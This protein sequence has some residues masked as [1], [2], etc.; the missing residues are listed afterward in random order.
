MKPVTHKAEETRY[1][2]VHLTSLHGAFDPRIFFREAVAAEQA[3]YV[4]VVIAPG[5]ETKKFCGIEI[6]AFPEF[7]SRFLRFLFAPWIMLVLALRQRADIYQFHDPELMPMGVMLRFLGK[8]VVY[9]VHEDLPRDVYNKKWLPGFLHPFLSWVLELGEKLVVKV[10]SGVVAS[11]PIIACRFPEAKTV[12]VRNFPSPESYGDAPRALSEGRHA[13]A[14]YV[15][16]LSA[17]RGLNIMLEAGEKIASQRP[18]SLLLAGQFRPASLKQ[19]VKRRPFVGYQGMVPA[20]EVPNV[21]ARAQVGLVLLQPLQSYIDA[22][23]LKLFEYMAAGLPVVASDFGVMREVIGRHNCGLL[24]PPDD[25]EA[26]AAAQLWL[27]EHVE[28]AAAMGQRG[29]QAVLSDYN[30]AS[31]AQ[32]LKYLYRRVL[33]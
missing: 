13:H 4:V 16:G 29:R 3:G 1:K 25:A 10:V 11:T 20:Q 5:A 27:F 14:V 19:D 18:Y 28:E 7:R 24:V 33:R 26:L 30:W 8:R 12:C 9:D 22:M 31:Q 32:E 17:P 2:I 23:P 15:G 21:L 6:K